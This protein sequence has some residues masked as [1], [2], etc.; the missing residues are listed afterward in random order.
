[1]TRVTPF[2]GAGLYDGKWIHTS[3]DNIGWDKGALENADPFECFFGKGYNQR[4][5]NEINLDLSLQQKLDFL[6]KGLSLNIKGSYNS[7]YTHRK[8]RYKEIPYYTAHRDPKPMNYSSENSVK[9]ASC[10]L[11]NLLIVGEIGIWKVV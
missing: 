8:N 5:Y 6:T 4:I 1:M 3:P 2:G 10:I 9:K 7:G 11:R